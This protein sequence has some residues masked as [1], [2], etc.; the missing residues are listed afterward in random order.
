[1][2]KIIITNTQ[3]KKI[4][5]EVVNILAK[6]KNNSTSDFVNTVGDVNIQ[7][8]INKASRVGDVNLTIAGPNS[9]DEQPT[10]TV[11]VAPGDT[12][13]NAIKNQTNDDLIR[14]GGKVEITG[15]GFNESIKYTKKHIEE[16]RLNSMKKNGKVL[17]KKE[18][19]NLYKK[20][21]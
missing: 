2:K 20:Q 5:E 8:D 11:N 12:P 3:L 13:Q 6:A 9:N 21:S 1:M 19:K 16:A 7:N 18:L 15:D 10:Q 14:S 4:N 17:T